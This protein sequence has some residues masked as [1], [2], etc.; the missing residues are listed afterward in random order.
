MLAIQRPA[1]AADT[2]SPA[3]V[4]RFG[5]LPLSADG[6]DPRGWDP[7]KDGVLAAPQNHWVLYEDGDVRVLLV[8]VAGGTEEPYHMHPYWSVLLSI[9]T[10]P[11]HLL[12]RDTSGNEAKS[13]QFLDMM[14][15]PVF[16]LLA[17]PTP[18][19][20]IKN[21]GTTP[22]RD[23]RIDFKKSAIPSL[24]HPDWAGSKMPISADGTDPRSWDARRDAVRVAP[25]T[26]QIIYEDQDVRVQTVSVAAGALQPERNYPL[27]AVVVSYG[28]SVQSA[29]V[30]LTPPVK[31]KP[32][33]RPGAVHLIR[34]EYKH[35]FPIG[36]TDVGAAATPP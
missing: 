9:A 13:W 33:A 3:V 34:I 5:P 28:S 32:E 7:S 12:N 20:S 18:M 6:S 8:D 25:R 27:P 22:D 16:M 30:W 21:L 19:H 36:R 15:S 29:T 10:E 17:P 11:T 14:T 35:G 23:I 4:D 31:V 1:H 24:T 26:N 2:A